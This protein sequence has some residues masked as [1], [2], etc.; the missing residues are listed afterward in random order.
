MVLFGFNRADNRHFEISKN[1]EIYYSLF[2]VLNTFYVDD[3]EPGEL[4]KTSI[5]KMLEQLDPYTTFI[6]ESEMEDFRF[7]TTGEYA[8]IGALIGRRDTG[9]IITEPYEGFPAQKS[10]LKA[11]DILL[12]IS[13][14]NTKG[15]KTEDASE[16]LKGP[17]GEPVVLQVA[18]Y[19]SEEPFELTVV[20][21]N[22]QIDPVTYAGMVGPETGYISLRS[23]TRD[24][25]EKV[26]EALVDLKENQGAK[27]V[28]LDLRGNP[29]GLLQEA[30]NI[31]NI[32]IPKNQEVVTTKGKIQDLNQRYATTK[33]ALDTDIPLA[34]L[35]N[36]GSASASEIVA[37]TMQDLDRGVII[38]ARTFGK[39]LVQSTKPL[40]YKT[41]LKVT[42]A[43]YY[44]PSG[45]CI[46]ALD[47]SHRNEDGSVVKIPDSL[48][49]E[50]RWRWYCARY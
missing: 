43:K 13:G 49:T 34:V 20:R 3:I 24:C 32:F 8:G 41:Q 26:K 21:E 23:F 31:S 46:Q 16:L 29:G 12:E 37:G 7:M 15:M 6:S 22:I 19:G 42:T 44:I 28:I 45:R 1:L 5:D 33:E 4:V 30:V 39:G 14:K 2:K 35:V 17:A 36:R 50:F 11:G 38:G 25:G 10:G 27:K 9:I 47:Y 40:A 48:I 18:R